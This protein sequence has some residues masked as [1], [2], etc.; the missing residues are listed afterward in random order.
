MVLQNQVKDQALQP[1]L[2]R[3]NP[4]PAEPTSHSAMNERSQLASNGYASVNQA[5]PLGGPTSTLESV[6]PPT[7]P[8]SN[9]SSYNA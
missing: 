7:K 9:A 6:I 2:M 3:S 5:Y 4:P 8:H 1:Q